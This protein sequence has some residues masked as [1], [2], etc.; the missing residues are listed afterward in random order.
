MEWLRAD[1]C[2]HG[3]GFSLVGDNLP[4][5][6]SQQD[7]VQSRQPAQN[8]CGKLFENTISAHPD[9]SWVFK[10]LSTKKAA[11]GHG[12]DTEP[13]CAA[14]P[15]HPRAVLAD[16]DAWGL[17]MSPEIDTLPGKT[18]PRQNLRTSVLQRA[19]AEQENKI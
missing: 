8:H 16:S 2:I 4:L 3:A 1:P 13:F 15:L 10:S 9:L 6:T 11:L 14:W 5:E 18:L 12:E 19:A 17:D 7:G